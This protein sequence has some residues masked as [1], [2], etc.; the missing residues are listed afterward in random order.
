M[1]KFYAMGIRFRIR[2][3]GEFKIVGYAPV[4]FA[5]MEKLILS[6]L[7]VLFLIF[8]GKAAGL[9]GYLEKQPMVEK[10]EPTFK[11]PYFNKGLAIMVRQP[12]NHRVPSEGYFLQ[13]VLISELGKTSPVVMI[14]EGYDAGYAEKPGYLNE[15]CPILE[16]NQVV[17]EHR[18]F[19]KSWPDPVNISM[20]KMRLLTTMPLFCC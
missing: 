1:V 13:R 10:V 4:I 7:I 17:V 20:W 16:A 18:Y 12:L 19:G 14:T 2:R 3:D 15:L 11:N 9:A 5:Q 8:D 6:G